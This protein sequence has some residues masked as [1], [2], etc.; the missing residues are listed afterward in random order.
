MHRVPVSY[1]LFVCLFS[2]KSK[3][4]GLIFAAFTITKL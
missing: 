2:T 1:S 4:P 3:F